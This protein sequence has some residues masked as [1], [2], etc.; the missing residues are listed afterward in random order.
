MHNNDIKENITRYILLGAAV[1][2]SLTAFSGGLA[3]QYGRWMA[4]E[5]Y[6][7]GFLIPF[8]SLW[9]LWDRRDALRKSISSPAWSGIALILL[10]C[11]MLIVGELSAIFILVQTGFIV[12]LLGIALAFGGMPIFRLAFL[13]I[14][15]L[16]FAIP[17]PYFLDTILSWRLQLISS[18]LGVFFIRI[19]SIP[20]FLE[21]NVIDLGSYKLQVVDACS[22]LRYLYP[23]SSLGFLI[24]YLFKA[25]FWQRTIV[26]LS[27]IPITIFMNSLRIGMV[28]VLVEIWGGGMADGLMHYF[29]GWVIFMA[30]AAILCG[31]VWL[32]TRIGK[33]GDFFDLFDLPK[34]VAQTVANHKVK[35]S[36]LPIGI[37]GI[38]MI[39]AA[40]TT[41]RITDRIENTPDRARFVSFPAQI[42][43]WQS[44][45]QYLDPNIEKALGFEDYILADYTI[46]RNLLEPQ[47]PQSRPRSDFQRSMPINFYVAYYSSQR[48]GVSPHSPRVCIPGGGWLI[49]EF[50]RIEIEL[51]N[52][53][54]ILPINR[55]IIERDSVRQ[56]VYYWFDQRGRKMSNEYLMK[57]HLVKDAIFMNR[58]DGAL[59]R[60][61]TPI[62][63]GEDIVVAENRLKMFID[64]ISPNLT[65]Y[66]PD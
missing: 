2:F 16:L 33:K 52:G 53:A 29:E 59:V 15:F 4:Q 18:E 32:F 42:D 51:A 30:C 10:S 19:F 27:T 9:M 57:W 13:P 24:A 17:M 6:S 50:D 61:T 62:F 40:A 36:S 44:K 22:G 41:Y 20:V 39:V 38:T 25:P 37:V 31:E 49:T 60:V 65:N 56:L 34:I 14:V 58:T 23:L 1:V 5:E 47:L 35:W 55:A 26:F 48:K 66:L 63:A 45:K 7:H 8:I 43:N 21:G 28:G 12:S 46:P 11:F 54:Q 64:N 3:N